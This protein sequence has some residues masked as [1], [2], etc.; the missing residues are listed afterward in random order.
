MNRINALL[1]ERQKPVDNRGRDEIVKAAFNII[2]PVIKAIFDD[3]PQVNVI[4]V[5][6]YRPWFNDGDECIWSISTSVDW[7]GREDVYHT[8]VHL[9]SYGEDDEEGDFDQSLFT[10]KDPGWQ[11]REK[12]SDFEALNKANQLLATLEEEFEIV[13]DSNGTY[14]VFVRDEEA[15]NG[16][17]V[18]SDTFEHD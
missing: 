11:K 1:A 7:L 13:D 6:G 17:S 15:P 10:K 16:F 14:W 8:P 2:N 12:E 18:Q 4:A 3:L 9:D 5:Q